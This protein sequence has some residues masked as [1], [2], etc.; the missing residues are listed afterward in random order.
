MSALLAGP[1]SSQTEIVGKLVGYDGQPMPRAAVML[2]DDPLGKHLALAEA[3][4]HG[5]FRFVTERK[6]LAILRLIG[7]N[8]ARDGALLMLD[9]PRKVEMF[10]KLATHQY[11]PDFEQAEVRGDS[12]KSPVD[13][14]KLAKQLDGTYPCVRQIPYLQK[15]YDRFRSKGFEILSYSVDSR[16][17]AVVH[18]RTERYPMPWLHSID[19][20]LREFESDMVKQFEVPILPY[21]L[22]IDRTGRILATDFELEGQGLE[23][24]LSQI[25]GDPSDGAGEGRKIP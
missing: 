6:G 25:S 20:G 21:A 14:R 12:R 13:G 23:K 8:H 22:L 4:S 10:A 16:R 5:S 18:F 2:L 3:A 7:V 1:A 17:E 24:A 9:Q 11:R 19:S 15:A